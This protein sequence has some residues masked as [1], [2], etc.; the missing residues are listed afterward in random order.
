M[1]LIQGSGTTAPISNGIA[2]TFEAPCLPLPMEPASEGWVALSPNDDSSFGTLL[3][4]D[5]DFYGSVYPQGSQV[6]INTNGNLNFGTSGLSRFTAEGFPLLGVPM[7]APFWA[8]VDTRTIEADGTNRVWFKMT[9]TALYVIWDGVGYFPRQTDKRNTFQVVLSNDVM[10]NRGNVCFC[11]ADMDWTTGGASGGVNG[12]G[13]VP[14]TVGVN[15]GNSG[16]FVQLGRFNQTGS[17][18]DGGGGDNDGVDFLDGRTGGQGAFCLN[19]QSQNIPPVLDGFPN[20]N[21]TM[22]ACGE[23]MSLN[24][25]FASPELD[26]TVSV[27]LPSN[28]PT[29]MSTTETGSS[30]TK[31]VLLEWTPQADQAGMYTLEFAATDSAGDTVAKNLT[32]QVLPCDD[33]PQMCTPLS[34][35][36]DDDDD[37]FMSGDSNDTD[38]CLMNG[39]V[40][41]PWRSPDYCSSSESFS[42][43]IRARH[44]IVKQDPAQIEGLGYWFHYLEDKAAGYALTT[45][46]GYLAPELYCCSTGAVSDCFPFPPGLNA[47]DGFVIRTAEHHA[48]GSVFAFPNGFG[49]V[50]LLSG[51]TM[52]MQDVQDALDQLSPSKVLVE[53]LVTDDDGALPM[54]F[55]FHV[56]DGQIG[57]VTVVQNR[58]TDCACFAEIDKEWNRLDLNGCFVPAGEAM[59]MTNGTCAMIDFEAGSMD[60]YPFKD[61]HHCDRVVRVDDCVWDD[62]K[63]IASALSHAIG[64]YARIDMF[65]GADNTVYVQE[66]TINHNGGL[67]HCASKIDED[68][69][70]VD[71]CFLGRLWNEAS[72]TTVV[73]SHEFGGMPAV[74]PP[75][76]TGWTMNSALNQCTAALGSGSG[77]TKFTSSCQ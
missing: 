41:T 49:G 13:G 71:S 23:S 30:M 66:Y 54:E 50:E 29:G 70:C 33:V 55:K 31:N 73:G 52:T 42:E 39:P 43:L 21:G 51:N 17:D 63:A 34:N 28:L 14:A 4:F 60:P 8:D 7:V 56:F 22:L 15:R 16:D 44:T 58:G 36:D 72:N 38:I 47:A 48:S 61:L 26:Q 12:F 59:T 75:A 64:V 10:D 40:C 3:P 74:I 76:L 1:S 46:E 62:M 25:V 37:G 5:F 24:L 69:G 27:T 18:Y 6:F 45:S 2:N 11:Y 9:N 32:I 35:T 67:R 77:V 19:V 68:T 57:S 65:V 53:E 20:G